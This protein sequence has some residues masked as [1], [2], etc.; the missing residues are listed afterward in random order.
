MVEN[1]I[2]AQGAEDEQEHQPLMEVFY[3]GEGFRE[4]EFL[5]VD[6]TFSFAD[7]KALLI[8]RHG[9]KDDIQIFLENEEDPAIEIIL[10]RD[11]AHGRPIKVHLHGCSR[12]QVSVTFNGKSPDKAFGPATTIAHVKHWATE[13]EFHMTPTDA[14]E[15][16]LQISGTSDRPAPGTH[17]GALSSCPACRVNFDLVTD[18]KIQG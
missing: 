3:Q 13:K 6:P 5:E 8:Q 4:V 17:L 2:R 14:G 15:H 12:I 9:L 18:V 16:F 11:H 7:L 10:L 1:P